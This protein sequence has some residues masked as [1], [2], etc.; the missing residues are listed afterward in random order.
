MERD[1]PIQCY[2]F[3]VRLDDWPIYE[4]VSYTWGDPNDKSISNCNNKTISVPRNL[5]EGLRMFRR[6][7]RLRILWADAVCI[8]QKD[9][10][11]RGSQV[12]L[13]ASI[14]SEASRVLVWL[15]HADPFMIQRA[16]SYV[17]WYL[18][19]TDSR[20]KARYSWGREEMSVDDSGAIAFKIPADDA[21]MGAL[22]YLIQRPYFS[23]G[24]IVQEIVLP[25][26]TG[27]YANEG[28]INYRFLEN[29]FQELSRSDAA[30]VSASEFRAEGFR[31]GFIRELR[32]SLHDTPTPIAF[33]DMLMLT[34]HQ[35]FS[36]SRDC[37][38]GLLGL[39]RLCRE[40]RFQ[41]PLF[42]PDY[43]VDRTKLYKSL[44]ET[45]LIDHGDIGVL[46]LVRHSDLT[47]D[48]LPSWIPRLWDG[49]M[50]E[51]FLNRHYQGFEPAE[52]LHTTALRQRY[53]GYDCLRIRGVRVSKLKAVIVK[54]KLS[55]YDIRKLS[56]TLVNHHGERRV[57]WTMTC[58]IGLDGLTLWNCPEGELGHMEAYR[59]FTR[60]RTDEGFKG[61]HQSPGESL[62]AKFYHMRASETLKRC[63]LF[64][65]EDN[66]L[67]LA[68][69]SIQ[70]GDQ[71]VIFLGGRMPFIL[72]PVGNK[73]S[74]IGVCY[75]YDIM[76]GGPVKQM[77]YDPRYMAEDFN[78]I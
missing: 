73:W 56:K 37:V 16:F 25:K 58:G 78:I 63:A 24:W 44:V 49:D 42:K 62:K 28:C 65:T 6:P 15:G 29:F 60:E 39:E 31:I 68:R 12:A 11:E 54:E 61:P 46:A 55:V 72:R 5:V 67:G 43:T 19:R 76:D 7:D 2:L 21:T 48:G 41:R 45:L 57:A 66:Q 36:D 51:G 64:E 23:R 18:N 38:Y 77:K 74:L 26:S 35:D 14:F 30:R 13:M 20:S 50:T 59:D 47:A 40:M 53:G 32:Q 34:R 22:Q 10:E 70:H 71:V 69:L 9:L 1:D 52:S 8:N 3:E 4:A 75:V 17:C 27:V 33:T